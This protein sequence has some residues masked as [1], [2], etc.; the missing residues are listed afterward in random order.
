MIVTGPT[1]PFATPTK[2]AYCQNTKQPS[3]LFGIFFILWDN[4]L[5]LTDF[6]SIPNDYFFIVIIIFI[7]FIHFLIIFNDF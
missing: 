3:R 7:I 5:A 1:P 6:N 2:N 4:E